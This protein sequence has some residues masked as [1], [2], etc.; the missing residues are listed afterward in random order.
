MIQTSGDKLERTM[1]LLGEARDIYVIGLRRSF[2]V[3]SYLTY[4]LRHLNHKAFLVDSLGDIFT[5]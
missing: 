3:V 2:S 5:E 4:T 1:A